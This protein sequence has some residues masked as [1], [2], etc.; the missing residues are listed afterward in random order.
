[1]RLKHLNSFKCIY[2]NKYTIQI[3][4]EINV[5]EILAS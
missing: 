3:E 2:N 5:C 4:N 1:M